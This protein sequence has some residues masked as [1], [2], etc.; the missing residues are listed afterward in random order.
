[1]K[2]LPVS[3]AWLALA[4]L[5]APAQDS[6]R[7]IAPGTDLLA[8][9]PPVGVPRT[10]EELEKLLAPIALY[11]DALI[12]L[13]LPAATVPADVVLAARQLRADGAD[14][15]QVE[16]RAWDE[17]VKSL[18]HYP[19]VLKWMDENLQWT[20]QVGEAFVQQ[21]VDVM[22][23]I[24][25]LR[26]RARAAGMLVDTPQQ[27]VL[28]EL[29]TIRI[30]PAQADFIYVP[31]YEPAMVFLPEPVAWGRP[32]LTFGV[33]VRVGSWLA[34]E[35]DW[36]RHTIWVGNRHRRWAGHDWHRPV[37][38][39]PVAPPATARHPEVRPWRPPPAPPRPFQV[40]PVPGRSE[41]VQTS[42]TAPPESVA[43]QPGP[44]RTRP[45]GAP[46]RVRRDTP[47]PEPNETNPAPATPVLAPPLV[48]AP[49]GR[50]P[51]GPLNPTP[52]VTPP[53]P[54]PPRRPP[55]ARHSETGSTEGFRPRPVEGARRAEP[56]VAPADPPAPPQTRGAP[57]PTRVYAPPPAPPTPVAAA[58]A[59]PAARPAL[60][61]P[62]SPP[63][64]PPPAPAPRAAREPDR[65]PAQP[66]PK[67]P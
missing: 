5:P 11:P 64:A 26:A 29:E 45:P 37:V 40:L 63:P 65:A 66:T 7:T 31:R 17:S 8:L 28:A 36:R 19:E 39:I 62:S 22:Q 59:P 20:K 57:P 49:F 41:L 35:C 61:P 52:E 4:V 14:R 1:M 13:I 27:Q 30:V 6:L 54:P 33:G 23:A 43:R 46:P 2:T 15:S 58:P 47:L 53:A 60:A 51:A 21:P 32:F 44:P 3:L 56:N 38:P 12:A 67:E 16:H 18:T 24:Q 48:T 25:R 10:A 55:P 50:V 34:H 42:P 9:S